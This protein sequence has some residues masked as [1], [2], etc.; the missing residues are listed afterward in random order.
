MPIA[1]ST[2]RDN[3]AFIANQTEAVAAIVDAP[4]ASIAAHVDAQCPSL[5][6]VVLMDPPPEDAP[7]TRAA[8]IPWP[9]VVRDG[10]SLSPPHAGRDRRPEHL[11]RAALCGRFGA[12]SIVSP[13]N[14]LMLCS[15][16]ECARWR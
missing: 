15:L 12:L 5:R 13:C 8:H 11:V 1:A 9:L 10:M 14:G 6:V 4:R 2:D 3:W 7:Q 16:D